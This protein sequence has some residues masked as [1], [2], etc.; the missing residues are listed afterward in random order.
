MIRRELLTLL[1]GAAVAQVWTW[2][3]AARAQQGRGFRRVGMLLAGTLEGDGETEARLRA[4]RERLAQLGWI[5]GRNLALVVRAFSGEDEQIRANARELAGLSLDVILVISNPVLA[6]MRQ[7][8]PTT[9]IVFVQVGDP[10]GSGFVSSL[11]H[12]GGT[13]TGFMHYEP[14]MGGKWLETLKEVS[15]GMSRA[16]VLVLPDVAANVEFLRAAQAAGPLHNVVVEGAG[17]RS[18]DD[19]LRAM[20]GFGNGPAAG[21]IVLPNPVT[22]GN[23][24][25]IADL[26]IKQRLST[27][28]A[29]RYVAASGALV[30]YGIDVLALF[31]SA[32]GYIDRILKGEKPAD[33]PVQAPTKY[34]LVLN[35]KTAKALGLDVSPT[36]I[37]RADEVIE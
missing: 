9:P 21:V 30:S 7:A 34:E 33:L 19:V 24:Q 4:L 1:G 26:A 23:R 31:Q 10:V 12:P 2:P 14:A 36:L 29:F 11:A 13:V 5:E 6:A 20:T 27:I 35:L 22:G 18:T 15:P 32:A 16:L 37:A 28:A 25:L 8:A 3:L 17:V